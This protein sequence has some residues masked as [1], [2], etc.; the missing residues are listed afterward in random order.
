LWIPYH[1]ILGLHSTLI[2]HDVG[3]LGV[4]S[5]AVLGTG[6]VFIAALLGVLVASALTLGVSTIIELENLPEIP[7]KN[8]DYIENHV[9]YEHYGDY[10]D[11]GDY[12]TTYVLSFVLRHIL[13][14]IFN[15]ELKLWT[16][17]VLN[18]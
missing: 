12:G 9:D 15:L 1:T 10:G 4:V 8:V 17:K 16:M 11:Y 14:G 6:T 5:D 3:L 7:F 2:R 18:V 13:L